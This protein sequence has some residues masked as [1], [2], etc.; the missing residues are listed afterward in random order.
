MAVL[1]EKCPNCGGAVKPSILGKVYCPECNKQFWDR[2]NAGA[3]ADPKSAHNQLYVGRRET[4]DRAR[5]HRALDAALDHV[6]AKDDGAKSSGTITFNVTL[7]G[8]EFSRFMARHPTF[9]VLN[10]NGPGEGWP[11]VAVRF[12]SLEEKKIAIRRLASLEK[13][14]VVTHRSAV[15]AKDGERELFKVGDRVKTDLGAGKVYRVRV[16]S[17]GRPIYTVFMDDPAATRDGILY[18]RNEEMKKV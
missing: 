13:N 9:K 7:E 15:M 17:N 1:R 6:K 8:P 18:C 11:E 12:N 16:D 14:N 4:R 2:K 5:M 3:I 10:L